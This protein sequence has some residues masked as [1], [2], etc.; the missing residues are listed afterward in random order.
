MSGM[1]MSVMTAS[2]MSPRSA[3]SAS[4]PLDA[5]VTW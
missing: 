3:W 2:N 4:A 1:R 5:P